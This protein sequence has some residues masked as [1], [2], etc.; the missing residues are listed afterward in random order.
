MDPET[1]VIVAKTAD[2]H[3]VTLGTLKCGSI[4]LCPVCQATIRQARAVEVTRAAVEWI[5]RGGSALLVTLTPR[6]AGAHRL[7]DLFDAIQGSRAGS[8][9]EIAAA[10]AAVTAAE[11]EFEAVKHQ[12]RE[13]VN[14]A[15][16]KAPR[17]HKRAAAAQAKEDAAGAI[18]AARAAVQDAKAAVRGTRRQAGAYQRLITGAAWAGE[19]REGKGGSEEGIR[20]RV[21]CVGMIRATEVT[22]SMRAGFHPHLHVL[23]FIGGSPDGKTFTPSE[24]A[25]E[26]LEGHFRAVWTRALRQVDPAFEGSLECR[27]K[28][29][30]CGGKG[31]AVQIEPV[32][33]ARDAQ[34]FGEYLAKSQ[35][36]KNIALELTRAD[37]KSGGKKE[38]LE[39]MTPVELL[40][41]IGDLM[42]GMEEEDAPGHGSLKWCLARWR[43]YEAAVK[44]RRAMEWSRGLRALLGITGGDTEEDEIDRL[45]EADGATSEFEAGVQIETGAWHKVASRALD[46]AVVETVETGDMDATAALVVAAGARAGA[47]KV[48]TPDELQEAR[49][50]QLASLA[51]RREKAA[52]RRAAEKT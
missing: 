22:I 32:K 41:R 4:W 48:M 46:L 35:E 15:S 18:Q 37:M 19:T 9:A 44:G 51:D 38:G 13:A 33:T 49:E 52:A 6:H 27:K 39:S 20:D 3:A 29:C 50:R 34:K 17:G 26:E 5:N 36:G 14:E 8:D 45:F 7:A 42:G 43:E 40:G 21:G 47:V 23:V 1:G 2:G 16:R 11:V 12:T 10:K 28:G 25:L 30:K 31:H 24:S